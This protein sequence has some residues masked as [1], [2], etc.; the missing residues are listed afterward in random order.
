MSERRSTRDKESSEE[1]EYWAGGKL[2]VRASMGLEESDALEGSLDAV[3]AL[4]SRSLL[5]VG[6]RRGPGEVEG[7]T[8]GGS[9][10]GYAPKTEFVIGISVMWRG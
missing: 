3:P 10:Q 4:S 9:E 1:E 7:T 8:V 6:V 2:G 5:L